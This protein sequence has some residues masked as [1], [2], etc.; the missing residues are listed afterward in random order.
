MDEAKY[1]PT[2]EKSNNNAY[3]STAGQITA[4][5]QQKGKTTLAVTTANGETQLKLFQMGLNL[6]VKVKGYY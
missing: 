5:N 6:S 3:T 2:G 1:I 4:I